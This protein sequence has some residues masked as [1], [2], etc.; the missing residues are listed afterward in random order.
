LPLRSAGQGFTVRAAVIPTT[1][2]AAITAECDLDHNLPY[3]FPTSI[4]NAFFSSTNHSSRAVKILPELDDISNQTG[5]INP[6]SA[7]GD[8]YEVM[9]DFDNNLGCFRRIIV[10]VKALNGPTEADSS[11]A[12]A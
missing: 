4:V 5:D 11:F 2:N 1:S 3:N 10:E 12:R 6:L 8:F 9:A 7:P